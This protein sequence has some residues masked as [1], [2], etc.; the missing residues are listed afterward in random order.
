MQNY[1]KIHEIPHRLMPRL[2]LSISRLRSNRRVNNGA[3]KSQV[4]D[5]G[6]LMQRGIETSVLF[7]RGTRARVTSM[8]D[9][10]NKS[11][12]RRQSAATCVQGKPT[13]WMNLPFMRASNPFL[14]PPSHRLWDLVGYQRHDYATHTHTQHAYI[15]TLRHKDEKRERERERVHM[16]TK[17]SAATHV[18][19]IVDRKEEPAAP[20][21]RVI[22]GFFARI[23][24][25]IAYSFSRL[26]KWYPRE[27]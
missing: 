19:A 5:R 7:R 17:R 20:T 23:R 24:T 15:Q 18:T 1:D 22:P 6:T 25:L 13:T 27:V 26:S 2:V 16:R 8:P 3:Y 12:R 9:D 21:S 11:R 14:Q 10:R 4:N